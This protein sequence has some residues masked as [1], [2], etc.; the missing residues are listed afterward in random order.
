MVSGRQRSASKLALR[1]RFAG[2]HLSRQTIHP[3]E[4]AV[5]GGGDVRRISRPFMPNNGIQPSFRVPQRQKIMRCRRIGEGW[6]NGTSLRSAVT[7]L[8]DCYPHWRTATF[9][10][11]S[12]RVCE[13]PVGQRSSSSDSLRCWRLT[14]EG[15]N[16]HTAHGGA[17]MAYGQDL[18]GSARRH[19]RA[20]I[21]LHQVAS[22]GSQ[23]GCK[24]VAGYLYG[25]AGEL[26]VKA[27]MQNSGMAPL[28]P[29][30]RRGDPYYAHFPDLKTQ[31]RNAA[32]GRRAGELHAIAN[33]NHFQNWSTDMRY[34]ST[35][36][37][38]PGWI[39]AWKASAISLMET[40]ET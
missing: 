5:R 10:R 18:Q 30:E 16:C 26:A 20:A 24:A 23:P 40:M 34:A 21:E 27:L 1:L 11:W 29:Q 33:S 7:P 2:A 19:L 4:S 14:H 8:N 32:Q 9:H 28:P 12:D 39:E 35:M 3:R 17:W 13:K 6:G 38:Q 31:L 22:A 25:M 15:C 36:E 37:V